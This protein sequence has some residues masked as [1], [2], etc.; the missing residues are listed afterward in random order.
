[1]EAMIAMLKRIFRA[2]SPENG[3]IFLLRNKTD[4]GNANSYIRFNGLTWSLTPAGR[5]RNRT[6]SDV[7]DIHRELVHAMKRGEIVIVRD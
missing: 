5:H 4:A 3:R 7:A 6:R 1:M 2:R